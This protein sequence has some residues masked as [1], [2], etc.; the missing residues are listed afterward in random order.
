MTEQRIIDL[1][2]DT[3]TVPSEAMRRAMYEA[4]VGDDVFGEDPSIKRLE[5]MSAERTGKEAAVYVASGTMSNLVAILSH[6]C[7]SV[8]CADALL[9]RK[10]LRRR[11]LTRTF[12]WP[13]LS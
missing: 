7:A 13:V 9:Q 10:N 6:C 3:V 2:S 1:R 4:P 11:Q 8:S 12:E 5:A